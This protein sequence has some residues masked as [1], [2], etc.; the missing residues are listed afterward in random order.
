MEVALGEET[1]GP[2]PDGL[3]EFDSAGFAEETLSLPPEDELETIPVE[4][5][6]GLKEPENLEES[7]PAE[8]TQD[9]KP[10]NGQVQWGD[11]LC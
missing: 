9:T 8:A 10:E 11:T 2:T 1:R 6:Q 4:E 7:A 3:Q 5:T